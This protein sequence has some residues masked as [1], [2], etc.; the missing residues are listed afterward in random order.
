MTSNPTVKS[1]GA[2]AREAARLAQVTAAWR[3]A[4]DGHLEP[5]HR[6]L[7][8]PEPAARPAAGRPDRGHGLGLGPR[9]GDAPATSPSP[10][11][12]SC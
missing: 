8:G 3:D 2:E 1:F 7:A 9:H 6:R 10:S 12:P 5:L 11:P 4:G